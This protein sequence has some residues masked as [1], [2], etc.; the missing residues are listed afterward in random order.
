MPTT[1]P[2]RVLYVAGYGRSGT[3]VLDIAL[4]QHPAVIGS[5]EI[6]ELTRH[7]WRQNEY[8]AC[9]QP[10]HDCGF[11]SPVLREWWQGHPTSLMARYENCQK[12]IESFAGLAKL[13]SGLGGK[14]LAF[15][16]RHTSRLFE[17]ML[18]QAAKTTIVDSSKL[19]RRAMALALIPEIDLRVIHVVRDGRG[20]AWS[21]AK[22]YERDVRS[23]LQQEI[24]PKSVSRTA[25]RWSMVNLETEYLSRRL[26]SERF[27]RLRY[28]DFVSNP[29]EAMRKIGDFAELDF[30]D[31]GE[32]LQQGETVRPSHQIAGN[33]L[34]MNA[35][36]S[37]AKDEAWRSLMPRGQ[38]A[39]F[40]RLCGWMLRRYG[41]L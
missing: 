33:R 2:I 20:V 16:G 10:V 7:V 30:G 5:G 1:Q 11:W 23:G 38:Q 9:G 41:Y 37:L 21:L 35:S 14:D 32:R 26:G 17:A 34:R 28:E 25:L 3:T 24:K 13:S 8:C 40:S 12:R 22:A 29:A 19:P 4:G 27:M 18:S 39:A 15:Y 36:I 6:A 31:I